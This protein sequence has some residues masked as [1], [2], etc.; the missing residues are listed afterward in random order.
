MIKIAIFNQKGGVG[1]TTMTVNLAS[2]LSERWN[3]KVLVVDADAQ[4]NSSKYLLAT[5]EELSSK[6]N[7]IY[8][9]LQ[10]DKA[11]ILPITFQNGRG[12]IK[13]KI[14]LLQGDKRVDFLNTKQ[15]NTL[16]EKLLP[17][18]DDYD[19]CFFD[20]SAQKTTINL[21]A[22]GACDYILVPV[23]TD[24]DSINGFDMAIELCNSYRSSMQNT[25]ISILGIVVNDVSTTG[26][27]DNYLINKFGEDF[28]NVIF[29][30]TIRHSTLL[31]QARFFGLPINYYKKSSNVTLDYYACALEI[32]ERASVASGKVGK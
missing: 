4:C 18:E 32:M 26:S 10:K 9:L 19:F 23:I 29:K 27:I 24:V 20:C 31:K 17:Y 2:C 25:T 30:S 1:K 7:T 11:T 13:T 28:Q 5:G 3:K 22:L 15:V 12:K 21:L 6:V 14:S 8:D 16:K